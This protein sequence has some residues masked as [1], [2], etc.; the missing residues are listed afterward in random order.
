MLSQA[1]VQTAYAAPGPLA[2]APLFLSSIVEPNI[3]FT[4]DDSGSMD[5]NPILGG[6]TDG[7]PTFEGLPY[8]D[9]RQRAYYS[10]TF[11]RLY[12]ARRVLPPSNGADP[13][14][15]LGWMVRNHNANLNYY[16][17]SVKYQPW[18]GTRADGS[19]MF[20]DADP[21]NALKD[22][23]SPDGESIDLTVTHAF[24]EGSKSGTLYLPTY[25]LWDDTDGDGI[26]EQ[27]DGRTAVEIAAGTPEMQNFANWFQY[28]RSRM[29]ATKSIIGLTINNTSAARMGM[30]QFND[31]QLAAVTSMTDAASKRNLLQN[32]YNYDVRAQGTP[33]RRGLANVGDY[34]DNTGVDAPILPQSLG[35]E[36]QRNFNILIGDGFW[37]GGAP[38]IGNTDI[39]GG[40]NDTI[41]DGNA[42]QSNDGRNYA[43][44]V[45]NTLADVAMYDYERD[46][47]SDLADRVPTTPGLDL[48]TH[49][50][51][52]TFTISFGP[53]GTLDPAVD[54]PLSIGFEWPNPNSGDDEK[55]DDMW[56]AAY[57]GRGKFL[58]ADSP[59]T[60]ARALNTAIEDIAQRTATA[61]AVSI[62]S[63]NLTTEAVVYLAQFNSNRWQGD[64]LAFN[65]A[66]TNTGELEESPRWAAAEK[67]NGR[68]IAD[69]PRTILTHDGEKGV[70]FQWD[71]LSLAQ[72]DDLKTSP[73]GGV[74]GDDVGVARV[75]YLRGDRS[76][77][78]SGLFFRERASLLADL[79]NSGPVFVGKPSLNWP[80]RAPFPTAV[81]Q[82]YTDFK[83]G[84]AASRKGVVYAGSNGGMMHGFAESDGDE[85]IAYISGNLYSTGSGEGLHYLTDP[86]YAHRY[87]N[88]LTPTVSDIYA[89]LGTGKRWQ[90]VLIS[91]QRGGGRGIYALNITDPADFSEAN[92]SKLVLWE[93]SSGDDPDLGFTYSRPQIGL[94]NNGKWVAIFGNGYNDLGSGAAQ[95]FIVDI[96]G[97]AD[98]SWDSGDII[99]ISTGSGT[100]LDRN[101]LATPSL[102]DLDG[103]GTI[104]RVYAGDL[105]G[106]MWAFD[107]SGSLASSW[108]IA[109]DAPLFTTINNEPITS[110]PAIAKHPTQSDDASN[111]PNVMVYFGSGQ[112]L[113]DAD[114]TS[115]DLTHFYGVWDRGSTNLT[116]SRLVQQTYRSGFTD[117]DGEAVRVLTRNAVDYPGFDRGWYFELDIG[118]ERSITDSVV[119]GGIV[120]F[121]SFVP[122]D[123][124]CSVG[125][126]GFRFAVDME[127]GG[128]PEQSVVDVN[129][130][131][132][133]DES[134]RATNG[135][136]TDTIAIIRQDGFLPQ[137]V[138]I[139]DIA[140][141]G[142][143]PSKIPDL[144]KIPRGRFSWQ[145]LIQ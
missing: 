89:G 18:P 107:L 106:Q 33:M 12:N 46:L 84:P 48:A 38:A 119:R 79:V 111:A 1:T 144:K 2:T 99:K 22:P 47:R 17:P 121:N 56:H 122:V 126:F 113:V 23:F 110:K 100:S 3:Y 40:S 98:G 125:G 49:Q 97:G 55:I 85:L 68:S 61:A 93:L 72:K 123:D 53:I 117:P 16:N 139:E 54:D 142:K 74:D 90:T 124:P 80:D 14:W 42:S 131:G 4:V 109:G 37:N 71:S 104:D 73:A 66:D 30:H 13:E 59:A 96:E 21:T 92:A 10:P 58:S 9:S 11:S 95:L 77:E 116:S 20:T 91:G 114:K 78:G 51:L 137:P 102:A 76:N 87:Y 34:F 67:L 50:H 75:A 112:Y 141:T 44:D 120:F 45:L 32:F 83:N 145:E 128:S 86:A 27:T 81:G 64:M 105:R 19:P 136:L 39:D 15:D 25:Y 143:K 138:F 26:I 118:G 82:R 94:A 101:G 41:F 129:Q 134:D 57:N 133:I 7:L 29:N 6:G 28:Y 65:I 70:P 24:T 127:T 132:L 52:V 135:V 103:N 108:G 60:L 31:G 62:N 63:T 43:D 88:D 36:C 140:Y 69:R 5:W 35:G 115:N 130:D 8:I